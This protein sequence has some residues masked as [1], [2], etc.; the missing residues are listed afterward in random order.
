M[1]KNL[2]AIIFASFCAGTIS[3]QNI[4]W[5]EVTTEAKPGASSSSS[6]MSFLLL[7]KMC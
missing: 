4:S 1:K 3:A 7:L 6:S 2:L 5:P